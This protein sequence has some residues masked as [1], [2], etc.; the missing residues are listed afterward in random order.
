MRQIGYLANLSPAAVPELM[1]A[2]REGRR[3]YGY[4]EGQNLAFEYRWA[5][6]L[7]ETLAAELVAAQ[8][9][10]HSCVGNARRDG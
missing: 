9:R 1:S 6:Q 7:N 2:L 3:D 4:V 10:C 8:C 5:T